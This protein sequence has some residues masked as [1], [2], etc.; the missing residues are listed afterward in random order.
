[1]N[2][3]AAADAY[4]NGSRNGHTGA[5]GAAD[6][7]MADMMAADLAEEYALRPA[8]QGWADWLAD[9]LGL[10]NP[11]QRHRRAGFDDSGRPFG[12]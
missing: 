2:S 10:G 5:L 9:I 11:N 8:A 3:Q 6:Q 1:M 4:A 7:A 12:N